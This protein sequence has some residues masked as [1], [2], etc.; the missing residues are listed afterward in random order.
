VH[1][2]LANLSQEADS[3]FLRV[4]ANVERASVYLDDNAKARPAWGR[5]P[6]GEL[7]RGASTRFWWMRRV[8]SRSPRP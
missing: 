4:S 5:T 3:A 6:H 7:V 2:L 1:H 8:F